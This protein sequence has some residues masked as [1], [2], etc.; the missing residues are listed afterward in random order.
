MPE[1]SVPRQIA[2]AL[3]SSSSRTALTRSPSVSSAESCSEPSSACDAATRTRCWGT[4]RTHLS[5]EC[6]A[7]SEQR[8]A[9]HAAAQKDWPFEEEKQKGEGGDEEGSG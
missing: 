6:R 5:R 1:C 9:R 8:P 7:E 3:K 4:R 2:E